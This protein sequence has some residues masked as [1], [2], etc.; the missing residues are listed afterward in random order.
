[1]KGLLVFDRNN[2][3][4]KLIADG[5][6][7]SAPHGASTPSGANW[8]SW[9]LPAESGRMKG[10][11][12]YGGFRVPLLGHSSRFAFVEYLCGAEKDR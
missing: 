6:H 11:S 3:E 2:L 7:A 5:K 10:A 1:M 9:Y 12:G 8:L 4:A